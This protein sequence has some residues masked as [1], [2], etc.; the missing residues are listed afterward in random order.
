MRTTI[1]HRRPQKD[2]IEQFNNVIKE[3]S[4]SV[5][6]VSKKQKLEKKFLD[7]KFVT[8]FHDQLS[9]NDEFYESDQKNQ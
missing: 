8:T 7:K 5:S 3:L 2:L 6:E 1:S 9:E 4:E